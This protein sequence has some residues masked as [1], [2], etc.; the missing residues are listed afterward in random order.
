MLCLNAVTQNQAD[1][2]VDVTK[3]YLGFPSSHFPLLIQFNHHFFIERQPDTG[4]TAKNT[5]VRWRLQ[6]QDLLTHT[7]WWQFALQAC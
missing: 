4:K 2:N 1:S 7:S 5:L 6:T 3:P